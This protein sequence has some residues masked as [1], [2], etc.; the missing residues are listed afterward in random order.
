MPNYHAGACGEIGSA[1][2]DCALEYVYSHP[3]APYAPEYY[4][5]SFSPDDRVIDSKHLISP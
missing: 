4:V 3:F 2:K 5:V 1:Q